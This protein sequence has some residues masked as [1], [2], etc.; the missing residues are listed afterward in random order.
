MRAQL[1]RSVEFLVDRV[2]DIETSSDRQRIG[3]ASNGDVNARLI[4]LA[5]GMADVL[6]QKLGIV[7]G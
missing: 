3:L 4:V 7:G 2:V 6:R 1:P 5:T